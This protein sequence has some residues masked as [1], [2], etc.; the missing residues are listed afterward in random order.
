M[1]GFLDKTGIKGGGRK[2]GGC[3]AARGL[4][5]GKEPQGVLRGSSV[6]RADWGA[7]AMG[8]LP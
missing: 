2:A 6:T 4:P 8:A 1:A 3:W 7:R 5:L